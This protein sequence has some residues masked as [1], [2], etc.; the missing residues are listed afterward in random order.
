MGSIYDV[1]MDLPLFKGVSYDKISKIVEKA[2]FHFLRFSAGESVAEA[3]DACTH[4]KC[5][6]SGSVRMS[7]DNPGG[8][9]R[10]LQ[11]LNSPDVISP[12]FLFGRN[13]RYPGKTLAGDDG[14]GIVQISKSDYMKILYNDEILMFNFLNMLSKD[15]QKALEGVLALT[16]G[17]L[18]ERVAF[19]IVAL[20]QSGATDIVLECRHRDLYSQFGVPRAVFFQSLESM[21]DRGLLDFATNKIMVSSR[22][23]LVDLLLQRLK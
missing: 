23:G 13:T 4:M 14:C 19:W 18:E 7:I 9:I 3:G 11:T 17:S 10:L 2:R 5:I 1:L 16:G 21:R 12:G 22:R 8:R 20:T 6:I 15:A